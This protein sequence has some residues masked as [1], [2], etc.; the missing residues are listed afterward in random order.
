MLLRVL[1]LATADDRLGAIAASGHRSRVGCDVDH[2]SWFLGCGRGGLYVF[3]YLFAQGSLRQVVDRVVVRIGLPSGAPQTG[4][5]GDS[6]VLSWMPRTP[7]RRH[8]R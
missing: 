7:S 1:L 6:A 5:K 8:F 2:I 4:W 3:G